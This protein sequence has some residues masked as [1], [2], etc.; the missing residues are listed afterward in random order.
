MLF[1]SGQL[2]N[3]TINE[4]MSILITRVIIKEIMAITATIQRIWIAV[5]SFHRTLPSATWQG[6]YE[7]SLSYCYS[8]ESL[9]P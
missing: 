8:Y 1:N 5:S 4:A 3:N 9:N 6:P 7:F 2:Q